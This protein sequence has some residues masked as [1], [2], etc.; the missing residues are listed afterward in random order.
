[1]T[2][3]HRRRRRG[4]RLQVPEKAGVERFG[5]KFDMPSRPAAAR[6]YGGAMRTAATG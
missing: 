6:S 1:M 5:I 2:A 4:Q 3:R